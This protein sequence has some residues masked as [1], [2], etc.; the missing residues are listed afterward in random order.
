M[1]LAARSSASEV[2]K[3]RSNTQ[4]RFEE[5]EGFDSELELVQNLFADTY[6]Q[7][8]I[9]SL[10]GS[11]ATETE[12]LNRSSR[13]NIIHVITHGYFAGDEIKS[14]DQTNDSGGFDPDFDSGRAYLGHYLPGL[15]SGLAMAG[16]N[17]SSQ[18]AGGTEDG[19]LRASE[20]EA[21]PLQEVELVVLSACETGLGQVAGGEGITGLQRSFQ[22]AGARSVVASLW[23][24]DDAATVELMRQFYTNL[25]THK[26]TRLEALRQAQLSMLD[27]Y[28]LVSGEMRGL[29]TKPVKSS[30]QPKTEG[31]Q[32][33]HPKFWA[34]FQLS[35]DWH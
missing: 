12:F 20:I 30:T 32:R 6:D 17:Q 35:G 34:A 16:A 13:A 24:V 8:S 10:S 9:I 26:M 28:D 5:L 21:S 22:I 14:L 33:L 27:H 18:D 15:L 3:L 1:S 4:V 19:I 2:R 29:G 31:N 11:E 7:A 23:K 25:W